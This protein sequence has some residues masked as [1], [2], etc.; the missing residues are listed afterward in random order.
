MAPWYNKVIFILPVLNK[1]VLSYISSH[2][3][4][5]HFT[6]FTKWFLKA[7]FVCGGKFGTSWYQ[8]ICGKLWSIVCWKAPLM[9]DSG[10]SSWASFA[11]VTTRHVYSSGPS[12]VPKL[13][14]LQIWSSFIHQIKLYTVPSWLYD[15]V[16]YQFFS[17]LLFNEKKTPPCFPGKYS[18]PI[19]NEHVLFFH[20]KFVQL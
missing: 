2:L 7:L 18:S 19:F 16:Y 20:Q 8:T 6:H 5:V 3:T 15:A 17:V 11:T 9:V 1:E 4:T 12:L 10:N 14:R 13:F